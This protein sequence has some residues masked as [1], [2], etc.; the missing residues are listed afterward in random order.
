MNRDFA[1]LGLGS[2]T[3]F[4]SL[5]VT[6]LFA[7]AIRRDMTD[8]LAPMAGPTFDHAT[9]TATTTAATT[10]TTPVGA[11]SIVA[12]MLT[13]VSTTSQGATGRNLVLALPIDFVTLLMLDQPTQRGHR[14]CKADRIDDEATMFC[15]QFLD[16]HLELAI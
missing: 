14:I 10:T 12:L 16:Q 2:I 9:L 15:I 4:S 7:G 6:S 13:F 1:C 3:W 11:T 5:W 8:L